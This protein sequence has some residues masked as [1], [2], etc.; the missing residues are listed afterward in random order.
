[1]NP[2]E[3]K[4]LNAF[5]SIAGVGPATLRAL[6]TRIGSLETAWCADEATLRQA[7]IEP[8]IIQLILARRP[9]LDPSKELE[10]LVREG[11]WL[12]AEEDPRFP[13]SLK[14]IPHAP[15]L[16][17]GKGNIAALTGKEMSSP[18]VA[19]VGTRRPTPYG[20]EATE[21]LVGALAER[22]ITI[23]SGLAIG[24]D[25]K[26]HKTALSRQGRTIA[27]LGSGIDEQ[28][29]FPPE[30]RGLA[31]RIIESDGAVVSEYP[32]GMPAFK[33]HFPQRNRIISGLTVGTLVVEA[34]EKSGALITA[35][36][37]L[38]QNREVFAVP[39]PL[40]SPT[41]HGP[42]RLIQEGAKLVHSYEDILE[43]LGIEYNK[44]ELR[45]SGAL[46]EK[47]KMM[48]ALLEGPR[49]VDEIKATTKMETGAIIASLS[50]LELK[51]CIRNLEG[52]TY[53]KI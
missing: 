3:L 9:A 31:R 33:E 17:Y 32:L 50:M 12:V 51:G 23:V 30:N 36:F 27:V 48:L 18:S 6:N 49:S 40:F 53:Q 34:R 16:L 1:M 14:E 38:E 45:E 42:H 13:V 21:M 35:R 25:T 15:L 43:E 29:L 37:A 41:S 19:V 20:L 5:N 2:R 52:D 46:D 11:I 4:F 24:I 7:G 44:S 26:A 28:S 10:K 8:K 39:G 47:E 22:G